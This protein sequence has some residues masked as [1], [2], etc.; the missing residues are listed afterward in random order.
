MTKW[1]NAKPGMKRATVD[2]MMRNSALLGHG[3]RRKLNMPR[4][5]TVSSVG[6]KN[7]FI[8]YGFSVWTKVIG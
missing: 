1:T 4:I 5:K 3:Y 7:E 6:F 2:D 8:K